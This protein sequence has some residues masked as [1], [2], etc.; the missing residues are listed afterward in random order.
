MNLARIL[1]LLVALVAGGAAAY[2][3]INLLNREPEVV[4]VVT[5]APAPA[6]APTIPT[7]DV[8]VAGRDIPVGTT[9]SEDD[10]S[11]QP[12][13]RTAIAET[14]IRRSELA[15]GTA[16]LIGTIARSTL[17][18]GEPITDA[19]LASTNGAFLAALLPTGMRAVAVSI[20]VD[21]GAGGFILPND[22]VDVIMT[23]RDPNSERYITE[24]ILQNVL[25]LA[26]DQAVEEQNGL[27]VVIGRTATLEL[28][29]EQS[30]II[31]VA[32]Q[33]GDRLALALRSLADA[34]E[35]PGA[36]ATHLIRGDTRADGIT[37]IR[38]GVA[39]QVGIVGPE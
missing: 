25:V 34:Q 1:V 6:P 7:D 36:D 19:K 35:K 11:W 32:Q 13:P 18:A 17:F 39:T 14:Y 27:P 26:I 16:S 38:N 4:Q 29:A 12:W 5:Q 28:S 23:R 3:A 21:T 20:S 30:E 8:L 37:V 22:R 31:T 10:L 9:I 24:T 33:M 2:L 15:D